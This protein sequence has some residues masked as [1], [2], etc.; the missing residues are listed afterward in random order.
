MLSWCYLQGSQEEDSEDCLDVFGVSFASGDCISDCCT[1]LPARTVN[2][3]RPNSLQ[4]GVVIGVAGPIFRG[5][6]AHPV[7][8]VTSLGVQVRWC[9]G[10]TGEVALTRSLT[11]AGY[12]S[13]AIVAM[14][15]ELRLAQSSMA[16]LATNIGLRVH[17]AL[18]KV[19]LK[20]AGRRSTYLMIGS[21]VRS[22]ARAASL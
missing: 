19:T 1:S 20:S 15:D 21:S 7:R 22:S 8:Q 6:L 16:G 4:P 17:S 12:F 9:H 13:T 2:P 14:I 18:A 10:V 3:D 5:Y 11:L